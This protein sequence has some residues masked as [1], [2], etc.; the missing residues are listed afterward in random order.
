MAPESDTNSTLLILAITPETIEK[1]CK[2]HWPSWDRMRP[3]HQRAWREKMR[4]AL[5]AVATTTRVRP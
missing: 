3:D 5:T 4:A 2:A 1:V